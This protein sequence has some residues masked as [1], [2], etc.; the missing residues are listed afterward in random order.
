MRRKTRLESIRDNQKELTLEYDIPDVQVKRIIVLDAYH[1]E[2]YR[3]IG[4]KS[5]KQSGMKR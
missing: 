3:P 2:Y 1:N 5:T 4:F